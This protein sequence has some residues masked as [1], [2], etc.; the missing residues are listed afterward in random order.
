MCFYHFLV[1]HVGMFLCFLIYFFNC[2]L[3][4]IIV[5]S[6]CNDMANNDI[7]SYVSCIFHV[8]TTWLE[9]IQSY[10]FLYA[11]T[12][13]PPG[14]LHEGKSCYR[15]LAV[16]SVGT[17]TTLKPVTNKGIC[18]RFNSY[19]SK[20][21]MVGSNDRREIDFLHSITYRY[22]SKHL[23]EYQRYFKFW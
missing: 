3:A 21:E 10:V 23:L 4:F 13:C 22:I 19:G 9:Y 6:F 20:A 7:Q 14:M 1:M 15:R 5:L 18:G 17:G 2:L 11:L 8:I 12:V 16:D